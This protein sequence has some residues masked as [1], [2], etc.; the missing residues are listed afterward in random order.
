MVSLAKFSPG[1]GQLGRGPQN[2]T[3]GVGRTANKEGSG[4]FSSL[5]C[6][7]P[8]CYSPSRWWKVLD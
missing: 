7:I 8:F 5:L 3:P 2:C 1:I 4:G 6:P